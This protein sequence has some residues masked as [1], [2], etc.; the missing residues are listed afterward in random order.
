MGGPRR[1][2][3]CVGVWAK[4]VKASGVYGRAVFP[5]FQVIVRYSTESCCSRRDAVLTAGHRPI[6]KVNNFTRN[7]WEISW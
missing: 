3:G 2:Y 4:L 6:H 5:T 1:E 7:G